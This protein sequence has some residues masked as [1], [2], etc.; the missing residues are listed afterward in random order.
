MLLNMPKLDVFINTDYILEISHV[1]K[2]VD[3]EHYK[4]FI[5]MHTGGNDRHTYTLVYDSEEEANNALANII[6]VANGVR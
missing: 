6:F 1:I 2:P 5:H 3:K 4:I